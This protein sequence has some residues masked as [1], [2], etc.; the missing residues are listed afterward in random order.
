M[1]AI[2]F[3]GQT[4]ERYEELKTRDKRLSQT[5]SQILKEMQRGNPA[6]GRG[7]L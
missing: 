2:S 3:E 5:L 7:K 4:W 6:Q 1:R